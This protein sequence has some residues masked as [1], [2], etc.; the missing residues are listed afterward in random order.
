MAVCRFNDGALSLRSIAHRLQLETSKF[1]N[2]TLSQKDK[3]CIN[4][5][6]S[7]EVAKNLRKRVRRKSKGLDDQH[8]EREGPMYIP[9][10][11]DS[12]EPGPSKRPF[13]C[14]K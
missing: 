7:T 2:R 12:E 6:S 14:T 9:G 1:C 4:N 5:S 13:T 8:Q 10:G 3:K 11:F